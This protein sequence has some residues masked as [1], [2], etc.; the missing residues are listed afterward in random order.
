MPSN[1]SMSTL[2]AIAYPEF[3]R[4]DEVRVE[5]IKLQKDYLVSLEDA[6][7]VTKG[8]DGKIKLHQPVNLTATGA[9]SGG[10]WGL[11]IGMIFLMPFFG[12]A[13]GMAGGALSGALADL[14]ISDKFMKD[15][16]ANL[17]N[18]SSALF[19]LISKMTED[20]VMPEIEKFG[21][22]VLKSSLSHEDEE[23]LKAAMAA[24]PAQ[25]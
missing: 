11:L 15:L 6:V 1:H 8:A 25:A 17:P 10:F 4:A 23:K 13:L 20:R 18:N 5:L 9:V 22:T 16:A 12:M 24:A 3:H 7:V 14:G 19:I 21:G 2:L